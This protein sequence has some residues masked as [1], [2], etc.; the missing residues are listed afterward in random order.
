VFVAP[1][2][3]SPEVFSKPAGTVSSVQMPARTSLSLLIWVVVL[4]ALLWK[5]W[6]LTPAHW[7]PPICSTKSAMYL[8]APSGSHG[9][10]AVT[11]PSV[12]VCGVHCRPGNAPCWPQ[13]Q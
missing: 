5:N 2:G 12:S 4:S 11:A 1:A 10:V 6:V 13:P 9:S 3:L 7:V 8:P